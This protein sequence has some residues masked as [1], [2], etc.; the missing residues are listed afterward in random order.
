MAGLQNIHSH[1]IY[2][3]GSRTPE[4]MVIGAIE[5]GCDSFGF[6]GHS[7][8]PFD[9]KHCMSLENTCRYLSELERLKEKYADE[10]DIYIGIEQDYYSEKVQGNFDFIIGSIH[11][12]KNKGELV[13]V[14]AGAKSQ[15]LA[16]DT[17]FGGDYYAM[18]E[19]YF[20]TLCDVAVKTG[21]DFIGHFDLVTKYNF[22]GSLFDETHPRY[23][24]AALGAMDDI[25]KSCR[26]F[27]VNTG[28]M[29]R[30]GKPEPYPSVFLIKELY[31][32]GGEVILSSDSHDAD[33]ICYK[34][35]EMRELLKTCGFKYA[36]RLSKD[37]F[38]DVLP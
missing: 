32:R 2:C 38:I 12:I 31:K 28:A 11:Y 23:V 17:N 36:K 21:A 37:G 3:D 35:A 7:Y 6:S 30:L 4:E 22:G 27:E 8:A 26:L 24:G 20:A 15:K 16:V 18:A 1:T 34:F 14:D 10:I 25:L 13:C 19:T 5:K 9:A 33:S 29:Y